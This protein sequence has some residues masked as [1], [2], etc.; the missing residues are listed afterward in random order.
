MKSMQ[1]KRITLVLC[2]IPL[3][4]DSSERERL[5]QKLNLTSESCK[6]PL[7]NQQWTKEDIN[8]HF[9]C[10]ITKHAPVFYATNLTYNEL[11]KQLDPMRLP[12]LEEVRLNYQEFI[13]FSPLSQ[14]NFTPTLIMYHEQSRKNALLLEKYLL[15]ISLFSALLTQ[16][17]IK[18]GITSRSVFQKI[19]HSLLKT[20]ATAS[21]AIIPFDNEYLVGTLL[22]YTDKDLEFLY[23]RYYYFLQEAK[24]G[25]EQP[26]QKMASAYLP[27]KSWPKEQKTALEN[28]VKNSTAWQEV[29]TQEKKAAE[30]WLAINNQYSTTQLYHGCAA[31]LQPLYWFKNPD[32]LLKNIHTSQLIKRMINLERLLSRMQVTTKE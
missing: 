15:E 22:G 23:Q 31:L 19:V 7:N 10:F 32:N 6:P 5:V 4:A 21:G 13:T 9:S 24:S 14:S 11:K 1:L 28:F 8:F 25:E 3:Y 18:Q 26:T 16:E 2:T 17:S 20:E 29:L 12:L 30:Q 27:L